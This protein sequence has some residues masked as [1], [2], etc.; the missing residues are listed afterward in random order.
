MTPIGF[1]LAS[2]L[3]LA[4]VLAI[5]LMWYLG[6]SAAARIRA[7]A[8]VGTAQ[9]A[10]ASGVGGGGG[11]KET[12]KLSASP[13]A[14]PS[15]RSERDAAALAAADAAIALLSRPPER[16]AP[17]TPW[18]ASTPPEK[19]TAA[20]TSAPSTAR[21]SGRDP[22]AQC[23]ELNFFSRAICVNNV[24]ADPVFASH[25]QCQVARLQRQHDEARRNTP[26]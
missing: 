24:C 6:Q 14:V 12:A 4:L 8:S 16:A 1:S 5:G 11:A 13:P 26:N 3:V 15:Q 25:P 9:A 21:V 17:D 2:G 20:R 23:A 7:G 19:T 22:T 10:T 18:V